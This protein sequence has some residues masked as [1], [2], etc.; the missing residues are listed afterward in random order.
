MLVLD[1]I[2][3]ALETL[4]SD[5]AR[6]LF[7]K[8]IKPGVETFLQVDSTPSLLQDS[9]MAPAARA[10]N[11]LKALNKKSHSMRLAALAVRVRTAKAGHFDKVI[12][13]I[14]DM[15]K[16]LQE[17]GEADREKKTQCQDE[18][19]S[20]A[21]TVNKLDWKIKNNEAQIDKLEQLIDLR[22]KERDA[23]NQKIKETTQYIKDISDERK[24][25][26]DA[27]Q[28][29]KKDDEDAIALLEKAR[30]EF[31][32]FYKKN[33]KMGE[34][35]GNGRGVFLQEPEFSRDQDDAPDATFSSKGNNKLKGKGVVSLF[36]YI[37]E[38]L[39]DEVANGKKAEAKSQAEF[40]EERDTAENLKSD[41]K[42]KVETLTDIIAKRREDKK[43][44]TQDME[45]N[46]DDRDAEIKYKNKITPDCDWILKNF[47]GRAAARAAEADGL[48]TAKEFLAGKTSLV[49]QKVKFDDNTLSGLGFLGISK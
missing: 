40:E 15:L 36:N 45:K 33:A 5:E 21:K 18:Y 12:G 31:T 19:Q 46:N 2:N 49:Q 9:S 42:K 20:I 41:L 37:I 28:Q 34:I 4:T 16:T 25:E 13:A 10:Y 11:A 22:N 48:T 17:E 43:D 44:E 29:A 27:F 26:H 23:A 38:D 8:S 32:A 6:E 14:D 47:D 35:Q 39:Y 1:G 24:E 7:A 30:K 3:A